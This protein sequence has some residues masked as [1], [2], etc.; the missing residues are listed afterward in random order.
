MRNAHLI[1]NKRPYMEE[2][3]A[4][5]NQLLLQGWS[6]ARIAR[7]LNVNYATVKVWYQFGTCP[8]QANL[9]ALRNL[10]RH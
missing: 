10:V 7:K 3:K 5:I 9:D 8:T 2:T 6:K 1:S 4:I